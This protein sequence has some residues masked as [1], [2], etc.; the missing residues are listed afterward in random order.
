MKTANNILIFILLAFLT[1]CGGGRQSADDLIMVDVSKNYPEKELIVQD[2]FEVEYVVLET[3]DDFL[4]QG[5]VSAIGKEYILGKNR[6]NDGDIFVFDRN[7]KGIRK[8]NR[9]GQ[10]GEEYTYSTEIVLDENNNEMFILDN[11]ARKI[12]VYDLFG[13]FK[14]SFKNVDSCFYSYTFNYDRDHL[15]CY[16]YYSPG[17][18]NKPPCHLIIS[19]QDGSIALEIKIPYKEFKTHVWIERGIANG[20][21]LIANSYFH[22]IIPYMGN[23]ALVEASSDTIYTYSPDGALNPFIVRTPSIY[24][25]DP[26]VFLFPC[27]LTDRYYFMRTNKKIFDAEK[28]RGFPGADLVYDKQ[29]NTLFDYSMYNGDFSEKKYVS[30]GSK[31]V[32]HEIAIYQSLE[33]YQLVE[34]Y[35]KGELKGR[36]K[37]I[38]A[39]LD[40]EDNPVIMLVKHKK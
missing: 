15:I 6:I 28:M 38:A 9:K 1:G 29:E 4:T 10:G 24:S 40:A 27:I 11:P 2:F 23:W 18:T 34:A 20:E 17:E 22:Q 7:G 25:M 14:R 19:K 26:E 12:L 8:I 36:L 35:E 31:P 5:F 37:E 39:T 32:N 13:N 30:M 33:A 3:T 16:K 21:Y